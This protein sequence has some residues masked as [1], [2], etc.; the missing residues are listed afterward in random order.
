ML[1]DAE[2][3]HVQRALVK[4]GA[5]M[6]EFV[7]EAVLRHADLVLQSDAL[8]ITPEMIRALKERKWGLY[9]HEDFSDRNHAAW[10]KMRFPTAMEREINEAIR[11]FRAK[12]NP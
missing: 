6:Y 4:S 10:L 1:G 8:P 5:S 9:Q 7:K 12:V 11:I 3:D 2:Y